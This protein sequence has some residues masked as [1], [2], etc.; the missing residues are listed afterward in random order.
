MKLKNEKTDPS[1]SRPGDN[2]DEAMSNHSANR[3][4]AEVLETR[5][6]R[7]AVLQGSLGLAV[8]GMFGM[9]LPGCGRS[10][11]GND[12]IDDLNMLQLGDKAVGRQPA[13]QLLGFQAIPVSDKDTLVVPE[14][15]RTQV[16]ASW[17]EPITGSFPAYSLDNSGADQA[18]Q[19]GMHHDG[20]HYFPIEGNGP[21]QG[22]SEDGLLVMNHEYV[23]PRFLHSS[24]AGQLLDSENVPVKPNGM[25]DADEV[26]K[27][28]N[29][30]GVSVVRI[31]K[32]SDGRWSLRADPRNRR[33]TGL[34]PMEI[35]GPL[36]G[37]DFVKTR[38]SP[39]GTMTRGT[40]NNCAHG[41]TPWNT[42][43][44]AEENW[45]GYFINRDQDAD[46][47]PLLPREHSRYGVRNNNQTSRYLWDQADS[48][49]DE[50]VR[51]DASSTG[52]NATKDYR[53]EPNC[54]GWIV[55]IN[56]FNPKSI[57]I[58]RTAL[59]RF[60]HEGVVFAVPQEGQPIVCYSG[61]DARN[62]Y[63]YKFVSAQPYYKA[64]A[65]GHLLDSGT[66]FVAK[67]NDDG[68]GEWLPLVFGYGPLVPGAKEQPIPKPTNIAQQWL[69]ID[70]IYLNFSANWKSSNFQC[71]ES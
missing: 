7:R 42:Y 3:H 28:L 53:N 6:Q 43:L 68:S 64:S 8:T 47:N 34:T 55:E 48:G 21:Y 69:S 56:P 4:F 12:G 26:L 19:I 44:A 59:G 10:E 51:F 1:P 27:E 36:R 18:D 52:K 22:S 65:G 13:P 15:Y 61:D 39:T 24:A 70:S 20:L 41:V 17:G 57:P 54:F 60:A 45:A 40:L 11:N 37:S 38:Y 35:S 14:G 67:F 50:F 16:I 31:A 33:I 29:A 58:K 62:E 2:G 25:R 49:A 5:L 71:H 23:E 46:Q 30:H 63:I 32:G 9:F 66:L